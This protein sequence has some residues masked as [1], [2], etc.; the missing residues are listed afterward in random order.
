[1]DVLQTIAARHSYRGAFTDAPV[2]RQDLEI[3]VRAALQAPSAMNRQTTSYVIVDD[4]AKLARLAEL[5]SGSEAMRTAKAVLVVG[6]DRHDPQAPFPDFGPVNYGASVQNALLAIASLG[7]AG[8]W[9]E[10]WKRS[11]GALEAVT[12]LVG[13]PDSI[14]A[15]VLIL[16]GVAAAP[17]QP[18]E[19]RAFAERAWWNEYSG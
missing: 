9:L 2:P 5:I 15:Q 19:K 6:V 17:G 13:L 8:L 11:E 1:M 7:Y 10:G 18:R 4:A 3:I 14:Q 16:I 12:K